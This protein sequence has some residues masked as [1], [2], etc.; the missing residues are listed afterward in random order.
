MLENKVNIPTLE[1]LL[2]HADILKGNISAHQKGPKLLQYSTL[3]KKNLIGKGVWLSWE[4]VNW[5][6]FGGERWS[7]SSEVTFH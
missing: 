3:Y 6:L 5:L 7:L 4:S 1:I 2:Y